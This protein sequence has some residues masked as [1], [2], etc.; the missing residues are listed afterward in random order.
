MRWS[1]PFLSFSFYRYEQKGDGATIASCDA[2]QQ[3]YIISKSNLRRTKN[4]VLRVVVRAGTERRKAASTNRVFFYA[5]CRYA[6]VTFLP[7]LASSSSVEYRS[8]TSVRRH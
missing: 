2:L 5:T 8:A 6:L 1:F 7:F 3:Y 4:G